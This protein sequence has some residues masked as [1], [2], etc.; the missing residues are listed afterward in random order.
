MK[1]RI[2][3]T[4][5]LFISFSHLQAHPHMAIYYSCDFHFEESELKGAWINFAFDRFF[6]VDITNT[7][8]LDGNGVFSPE[9]TE[10]IYNHAFI[11]L[12]HYGF[13][14]SIRDRGGR[15]SPETVSDFYAYTDDEEIL[16]Y[17]FY[18]NLKENR[19][20]EFYLSVYDPTFFC[21]TYMADETPVSVTADPP[22]QSSYAIEENTDY[23]VYYDPLAPASDTSTYDEWR[24]GLNT[25]FPEEIHFVY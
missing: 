12:E 10:E 5:F 24:P 17:R 20:R 23:P 11:N 14:I 18:I 25:Y 1:K 21:A 9:E 19:E 4:L 22:V 6:S 13:F 7:Y 15:T 3:Y 2:L 8:D 16:N